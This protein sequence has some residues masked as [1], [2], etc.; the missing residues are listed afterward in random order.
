MKITK[1]ELFKLPPRWLFLKI[2]TD[3]GISG[4]GE[5]VVEGKADTVRAAVK[6]MEDYLIGRNPL[7]IEDIW[8]TLYRGAFYRG[9]PVLMSAIAGIDQALWDI[10]GKFL[11]QPVY[12]LL[13]GKV[14]DKV[15]VYSWIGGDRPDNVAQAAQEKKDAGFTAVKMNGTEE[16]HYIDSYKKV[17]QAVARVAAIRD[18]L[19]PD[20]GIA[21]DFHGRVHKGMA[22]IL[23]KELEPFRL[24]FIEE[25]V[26]SENIEALATMD[27]FGIPIALGERL[28]SRWDYKKVFELNKVDIIQPD[29]SHA[30]G[31]SEVRKIAAM[32]EAYDTAVAPHS[33]L[34]PINLAASLQ[35]DAVCPNVFIQEQSLGIHY[36]QGNDLLDYLK[37]KEVFKYKAGYAEI[38]YQP[39]LGIEI[40]E[41]LVRERARDSHN[42]KNPVWRNQDG[43]VA[44]W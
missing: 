25:P 10:K 2:S 11:E 9:G 21:V 27:T 16:L 35:I 34:G 12:E 24:M 6:E 41:D 29:L 44:E 4:W 40:N 36:N 5:P 33:P 8:Q 23:F 7:E 20:F 17:D 3:Q 43:T 15:R 1:L 37:N 42:W 22:R 18:Q 13:G 39:G 14:R 32:A 28:F 38:P 31:I 19:G 30:G 26:L